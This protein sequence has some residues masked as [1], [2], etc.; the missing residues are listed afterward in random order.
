MRLSWVHPEPGAPFQQR[1]ANGFGLGF[2]SQ[3]G[4][5]SGQSLDLGI[6]DVQRRSG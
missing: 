3:A 1:P 2:V 6:L 4:H 5:F